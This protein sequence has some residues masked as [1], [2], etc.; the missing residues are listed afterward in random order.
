MVTRGAYLLFYR[1][2][3]A[4]QPSPRLGP[5]CEQ[6]DEEAYESAVSDNDD[7]PDA[8]D[9]SD[10]KKSETDNKLSDDDEFQV[11]GRRLV[12]DTQVNDDDSTS[13]PDLEEST[14]GQITLNSPDSRERLQVSEDE[15]IEETEEELGYTDMDAVD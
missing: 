14:Q 5:T 8:K 11:P 13:L 3:H 10:N 15:N 12:I 6:S 2:R 7:G 1:R 4:F 9:L